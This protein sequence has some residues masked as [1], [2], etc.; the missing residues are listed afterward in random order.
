MELWLYAASYKHAS[1]VK[2]QW[3][4]QK[5]QKTSIVSRFNNLI[6]FLFYFINTKKLPAYLGLIFGKRFRPSYLFQQLKKKFYL[7]NNNKRNEKIEKGF[8]G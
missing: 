7:K 1:I 6:I 2:I 5:N 3:K 4:K 8:S